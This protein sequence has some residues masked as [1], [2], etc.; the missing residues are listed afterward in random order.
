MVLNLRQ[1][2]KVVGLSLKNKTIKTPRQFHTS[3]SKK[4][5]GEFTGTA[6]PN[7]M[8]KSLDIMGM[9]PLNKK[10]TKV[11]PRSLA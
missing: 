1:Y 3:D 8:G 2:Q 9:K 7:K 6:I 10:S 5:V 4:G 11:K